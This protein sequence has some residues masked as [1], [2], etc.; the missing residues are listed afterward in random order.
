MAVKPFNHEL[1]NS[2][3]ACGFTR[4]EFEEFFE[5]VKRLVLTK[6]RVSELV[7]AFERITKNDPLVMRILAYHAIE[8]M[9]QHIKME[10]KLVEMLAGESM[11]KH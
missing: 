11:P 8:G 10:Q 6:T 2:L 5:N 9:I 4:E 3:E 1:S 7:E